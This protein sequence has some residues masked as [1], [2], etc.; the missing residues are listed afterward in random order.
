MCLRD[1]DRDELA[2][3]LAF[4]SLCLREVADHESI[5]GSYWGDCEAGLIGDDVYARADTPLHSLLHES[6]HAIVMGKHRRAA[7]DKDAGGD[8]DE[9]NAVCFLQILLADC[10]GGVGRERMF[11]D[12]DA[13]GYT[14]RLGAAALW[15]TQDAEQAALDLQAAGLARCLAGQWV[16]IVPSI[17][18]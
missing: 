3:L 10:L 1:I 4:F 11:K 18:E 6:S 12:M 2:S 14:F 8:F 5:P 13:W 9:E 7:L 16:A 17:G 15:F